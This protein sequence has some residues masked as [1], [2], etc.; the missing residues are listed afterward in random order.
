VKLPEVAWAPSAEDIALAAYYR[1]LARGD[2]PGSS[3]EDWLEA[4]REL[5]ARG[6]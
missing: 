6:P 1:Y 2:R 5:I 4:E 3:L